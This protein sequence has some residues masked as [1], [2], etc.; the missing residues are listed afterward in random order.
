MT[1]RM[2]ILALWGGLIFSL[3]FTALIWLT[4]DRLVAFVKPPDQGLTSVDI[5]IAFRMFLC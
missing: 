2:D 3:A 5:F 1:K 4:G